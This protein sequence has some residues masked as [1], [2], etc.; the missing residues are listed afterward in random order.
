MNALLIYPKYPNTF[1]SF[2]HALKFVS[3]KA[4]FP[5]L[6]LMTIGAMLPEEWDKK[7]IDVNVNELREEH[8]AWADI[9]LISA[10][11]VQKDSSQ[12]IINRCKVQGKKVVVGGPAFTTQPENFKGVD[13][14]VLNE[15][16]VTL[17]LFLRDLKEENLKRIYTSKQRPDI[18]GTP[19]P[20]WSLINF[21]DYA[22]M[23]VQ[24]SRGCPFNCEFCDIIIMNGRIPRTKTPE[25]L[26]NELQ[27]LYDAGWRDSLFIVDDNFIGNKSNVKKML[28]ALIEWQKEHKYP[29]RIMTEA[30]MNLANDEELMDM[31]SAA[32]FHKVFLGIETPDIDSLKECDKIQNVNI[33]TME[34][35]RTINQ[36][37][38]QVVGGFIVGFDSDTAGIFEAQ[39]KFIQKMGIVTAMVGLLNA[40][41]QTRLWHRLKAEGRLLGETSGENT[42]GSLNFIPKMGKKN[43]IEG[44]NKI[45]STIYSPKN[46]YNRINTFIKNYSPTVKGKISK[47]DIKAFLKSTWKVGVLSKA[48]LR[49][50]RLIIET[51]LTKR[52]ALPIAVELAIYRQHF[53]RIVKDIPAI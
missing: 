21:K 23:A 5:P 15:A 7:L 45:L 14:F 53:E 50:W 48:R 33:D 11:I 3:K 43:L 8:I 30:S 20:L 1:W 9:V 18:T 40:A 13:H 16:E 51:S 27:L 36:K 35:V 4:A 22:T 42:D 29:F 19:A 26:I 52:K 44:Y 6:G 49:Y 2:K 25:Q 41:P 32:N 37:G 34:A 12:E 17:P 39:I 46:Y 28:H 47:G 38:M 31:M 24:Y 10:M